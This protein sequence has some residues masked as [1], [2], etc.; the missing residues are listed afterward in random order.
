MGLA[1]TGVEFAFYI[2]DPFLE[3]CAENDLV[4]ITKSLWLRQWRTGRGEHVCD[5]F[6]ACSGPNRERADCLCVTAPR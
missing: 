2:K 6:Q 3:T 1:T 4:D 5:T